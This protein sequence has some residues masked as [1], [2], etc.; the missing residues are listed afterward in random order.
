MSYFAVNVSQYDT[1]EVRP[2][3]TQYGYTFNNLFGTN[4]IR[5]EFGVTGIPTLFVIDKD[6][7]IRYIHDQPRF[8]I[9]EVLSWQLDDLLDD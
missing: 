3:L 7:F 1:S 4:K 6:G 2:Y 8:D 5:T 9:D